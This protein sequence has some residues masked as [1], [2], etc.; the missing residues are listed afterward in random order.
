MSK[1]TVRG[2]QKND[3]YETHETHYQLAIDKKTFLLSL[4]SLTDTVTRILIFLLILVIWFP[5]FPMICGQFWRYSFN[6]LNVQS[7]ISSHHQQFSLQHHFT[8]FYTPSKEYVLQVTH[9]ISHA[10]FG[11]SLPAH[12]E[13]IHLICRLQMKLNVIGKKKRIIFG[14]L[15]HESEHILVNG[16]MFPS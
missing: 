11:F 1:T 3:R 7:P 14:F 5:L 13:I 6:S 16:Q 8:P 15:D 12:L 10:V 9:V 2:C 4:G